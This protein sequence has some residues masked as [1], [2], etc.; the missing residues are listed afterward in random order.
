MKNADEFYKFI[1]DTVNGLDDFKTER[2]DINEKVNFYKDDKSC[3]RIIKFVG[4]EK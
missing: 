2:A 3:E 4:I 1:D